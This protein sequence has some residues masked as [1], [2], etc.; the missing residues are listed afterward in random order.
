MILSNAGDYL[1]ENTCCGNI[2]QKA[3]QLINDWLGM[4]LTSQIRPRP[5]RLRK[6]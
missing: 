2:G 6:L 3:Y 1:S 4:G 5:Q